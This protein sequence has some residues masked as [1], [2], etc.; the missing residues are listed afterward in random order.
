MPMWSVGV[1]MNR[2]EIKNKIDV[3]E[4]EILNILVLGVLDERL[5]SLEAEKENLQA[6]CNHEA[7][8]I[9]D[10]KE[11]CSICHKHLI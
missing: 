1:I 9:E 7:V 11:F 5:P 3:I 10:G 2:N 6:M 8:E 4:S